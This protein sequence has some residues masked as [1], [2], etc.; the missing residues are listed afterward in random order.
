MAVPARLI[1]L[2]NTYNRLHVRALLKT[3]KTA[4]K[5]H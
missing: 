1:A 4:R 3:R 5:G 2:Q